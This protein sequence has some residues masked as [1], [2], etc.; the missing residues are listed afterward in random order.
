V[1]LIIHLNGDRA[2]SCLDFLVLHVAMQH[3]E[4]V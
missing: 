2:T 3:A 4:K 1:Y